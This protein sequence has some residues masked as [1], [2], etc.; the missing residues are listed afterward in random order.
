MKILGVLI[1]AFVLLVLGLRF[2]TPGNDMIVAKFN[3]ISSLNYVEDGVD[4]GIVIHE[5]DY[6]SFHK[7]E[8]VDGEWFAVLAYH[9]SECRVSLGERYSET[10][11]EYATIVEEK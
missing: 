3:T 11:F 9:G 10:E 5:G 6:L 7:L 2:L 4:Y 8:E 1:L